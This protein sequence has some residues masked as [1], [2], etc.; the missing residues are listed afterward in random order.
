MSSAT[1]TIEVEID[2]HEIE[3]HR[4]SYASHTVVG[5]LVIALGSLLATVPEPFIGPAATLLS[6]TVA[7]VVWKIGR[8]TLLLGALYAVPPLIIS[9]A[10]FVLETGCALWARWCRCGLSDPALSC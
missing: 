10:L 2:R 5:L 9:T 6:L 1:A 4:P 3:T 7:A 8:W